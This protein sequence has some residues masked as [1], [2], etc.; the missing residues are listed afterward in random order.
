VART[1]THIR[2]LESP[3]DSVEFTDD[4]PESEDD[5]ER[6]SAEPAPGLWEF[7]KIDVLNSADLTEK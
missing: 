1:H 6:H 5:H 3:V 2:V 4:M 7:D